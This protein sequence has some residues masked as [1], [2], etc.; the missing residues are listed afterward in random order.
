MVHSSLIVGACEILAEHFLPGRFARDGWSSDLSVA[1]SLLQKASTQAVF[2]AKM[3]ASIDADEIV[4]IFF[5]RLPSIKPVIEDD[6]T[7]SYLGDPAAV[8]KDEIIAAYPGI[9]AVTVQ[10]LAHELYSYKLPI[11]P[12]VMTEWA[13]S[14]T[15]IDIHPGAQLG[16]GFFIDHGTAVVIGETAVVGKNVKIYQGATLGAKSF[17]LDEHGNPVKG[18]KRHPTVEDDVVIYANAVI[19][20]GETVIGRGSVIGA[21]VY[22]S[23]SV[24]PHSIV[25]VTR[26]E[27]RVGSSAQKRHD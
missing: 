26:P 20:G 4:Q 21:G 12:R 27:L 7:A 19:L 14:L 22:L 16:P 2:S 15:G 5:D 10:R 13:H 3:Q 1:R 8:S 18:I 9:L 25:S 6:I 11:V 17:S 24:P 23:D